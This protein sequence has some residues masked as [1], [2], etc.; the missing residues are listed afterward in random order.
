MRVPVPV[1]CGGVPDP[2]VLREAVHR[3]RDAGLRPGVML[4][5]LPDNPT[6]TLAA[7]ELVREL[8][9]VAEEEELVIVSDEIYRDLVHDPAQPFL[10]PAEV[11]PGRTIVLT[12][13][14]KSLALGGWRIGAARFPTGS[15][16]NGIRDRVAGYASEVWSTLA[17]PMQEVAA[18][19]FAEPPE[20][21]EHLAASARLH[22]TVARAVHAIV[23]GSG[24]KCRAPQAGFYLYPDYEPL[25]ERLA[26]HGVTDSELLQCRLLDRAGIAVLAGHHMGDDPLALRARIATSKL[27]GETTDEQWQALTSDDPVALP[28]IAGQL[29]AVDKRLRVLTGTP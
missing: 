23:V 4:L 7:P 16:G 18:Y 27:Y 11:L 21:R 29:S 19:A 9:A 28:H 26:A 5:T 25:R 24:A 14:S 1:S 10:S 12:G 3:A 6:G 13:L 22:G 15:W 17:G 2:T 8:C 20:L